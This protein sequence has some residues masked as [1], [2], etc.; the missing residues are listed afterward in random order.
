MELEQLRQLE[1]VAA[2]GT[3][4]AAAGRASISQPALSRSMQRLEAELGMPLFARTKNSVELNEAGRVAL[5]HARGILRDVAHM[6]EALG[7]L[8]ARRSMLRVGTCAP[9]PLWRLMAAVAERRAD[10]VANPQTLPV[11]ELERRL[12]EGSLDFAILPHAPAAEG[13]RSFPFMRESL[14]ALLP[15]SHPLA[16]RGSLA[17]SELDGET[18]LLYA[19]I[20]FWRGLCER[21]MPRSHY[22]T[23]DDYLVFSQLARTSPLPSFV[24]DAAGPD[25]R[26]LDRVA[27]PLEDAAVHVTFRLATPA[28]PRAELRD[29]A[30]WLERRLGFE[31]VHENG[32]A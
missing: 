3:L 5:E 28:A 18:F 11:P 4:S 19:G 24:T 22:V 26:A 12:V 31:G 7:N 17:L 10:L 14:S 23:Q 16:A 2:C 21:L 6:E 25:H 9:A 30:D 8:R 29:L 15:R 27:V 20:G 13:L 32:R 1:A